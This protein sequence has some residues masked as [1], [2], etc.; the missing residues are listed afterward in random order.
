MLKIKIQSKK[1]V[2]NDEIQKNTKWFKKFKNLYN[3]NYQ[4][5][6]INNI[7]TNSEKEKEKEKINEKLNEKISETIYSTK[8]SI[9]NKSIKTRPNSS[10]G[11]KKRKEFNEYYVGND[12]IIKNE[13]TLIDPNE[14]YLNVLESQQLFVNSRLNNIE[15]ESDE[16]TDEISDNNNEKK[17]MK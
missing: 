9:T 12:S 7:P 10:A 16:E 11:F 6:N 1:K 4:L 2:N 5:I 3:L 17:I 13:S 14:Y 8:F 15:N